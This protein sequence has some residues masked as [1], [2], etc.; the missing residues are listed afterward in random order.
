MP[1][2]STHKAPPPL[3]CW[4][5][6]HARLTLCH[7]LPQSW[8]VAFTLL[9]MPWL[10]CAVQSG[11]KRKLKSGIGPSFMDLMVMFASAY[12]FNRN[13]FLHCFHSHHVGMTFLGVICGWITA[14]S[15]IV[16]MCS[17]RTTSVLSD[18]QV[19]LS[20]YVPHLFTHKTRF[21]RCEVNKK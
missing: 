13:C 1:K 10:V 5:P 3:C 15:A 18:P 7:C 6:F 11:Q 8:C 16:A 14:L 20:K 2:F 4:C 12:T 21:S 19:H 17:H 9:W